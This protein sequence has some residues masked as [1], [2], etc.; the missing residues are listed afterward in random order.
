MSMMKTQMKGMSEQQMN[1][2]IQ[3]AKTQMAPIFDNLAYFSMDKSSDK[4]LKV[5]LQI[6]HEELKKYFKHLSTI[7]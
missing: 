2:M 3:M 6:N 4:D 1:M 7:P 5:S